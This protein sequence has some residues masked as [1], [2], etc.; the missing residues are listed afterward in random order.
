MEEERMATL[1]HL[2]NLKEETTNAIAE[3]REA[4]ERRNEMMDHFTQARREALERWQS[5]DD[6]I[7]SDPTEDI[8]LTQAR[9][10]ETPEHLQPDRDDPNGDEA[11]EGLVMTTN[12]GKRRESDKWR[13]LKVIVGM[14]YGTDV[15][16]EICR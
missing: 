15:I 9:V 13:A 3:H 7:G 14:R 2:L 10:R 5:I 4:K 8:D 12:P 16:D 6:E 1:Q 11:L